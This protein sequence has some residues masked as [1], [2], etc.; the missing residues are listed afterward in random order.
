MGRVHRLRANGLTLDCPSPCL[1]HC[2]LVVAHPAAAMH[3]H[4]S[5]GLLSDAG[6]PFIHVMVDWG[7]YAPTS[8][9]IS[10]HESGLATWQNR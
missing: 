8:W 6:H 10:A 4:A 7:E 5:F 3:H 1:G 9:D 2:M